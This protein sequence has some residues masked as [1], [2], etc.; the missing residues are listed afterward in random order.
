MQIQEVLVY[1][2]IGAYRLHQIRLGYHLRG[3]VVT[4]MIPRRVLGLNDC[5]TS[6]TQRIVVHGSLRSGDGYLV[7]RCRR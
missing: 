1:S 5:R 6:L 4:V 3:N 7:D 2:E